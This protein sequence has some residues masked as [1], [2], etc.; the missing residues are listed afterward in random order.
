[1]TAT[2]VRCGVEFEL[3]V[4]AIPDQVLCLDCRQGGGAQ[5]DLAAGFQSPVQLLEGDNESLVVGL[6]LVLPGT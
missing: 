2:C 6:D 1:M 5:A 3:G 4:D